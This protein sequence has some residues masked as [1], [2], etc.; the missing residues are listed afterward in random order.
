MS[1]LPALD[2]DPAVG[3]FR[4]EVR[5]WLADNWLGERQAAH[6]KKPF[7]ERGWDAEFSRLLG[8]KGWIGLE[9]GRAHV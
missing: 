5:A 3:A 8:R 4:E 6:D 2:T 7:K 1:T 9:I